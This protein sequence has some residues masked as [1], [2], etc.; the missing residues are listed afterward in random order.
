MIKIMTSCQ[1][2]SAIPLNV[3]LDYHTF[4][5]KCVATATTTPR[6]PGREG[7]GLLL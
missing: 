6:P 5:I 3:S 2:V 4:P 1:P 7:N